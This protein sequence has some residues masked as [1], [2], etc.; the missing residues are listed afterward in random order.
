MYY[1]MIN[2]KLYK[3]REYLIVFNGE[4]RENAAK[5]KKNLEGLY[6]DFVAAWRRV[7]EDKGKP[8][9]VKYQTADDLCD[10]LGIDKNDKHLGKYLHKT[11]GDFINAGYI[12]AYGCGWYKEGK[13]STEL[14]H[15]NAMW[16]NQMAKAAE[17]AEKQGWYAEKD[18]LIG[19]LTRAHLL[20]NTIVRRGYDYQQL[21][22]DCK[23]V[24][25]TLHCIETSGDPEWKSV[26]NLYKL[27]YSDSARTRRSTQ[28]A[29][30][31]SELRSE[32]VT[33]GKHAGSDNATYD[34]YHNKRENNV[35]RG[36]IPVSEEYVRFYKEAYKDAYKKKF[37]KLNET[38]DRSVNE[39]MSKSF[40]VYCKTTVDEESYFF[41]FHMKNW[42]SEAFFKIPLASAGFVKAADAFTKPHSGHQLQ[43]IRDMLK[44]ELEKIQ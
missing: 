37:A 13:S 12:L 31:D 10:F 5:R 40:V 14:E 43:V 17:E 15:I 11:I 24:E 2:S 1:T 4:R 6:N 36:N 35:V 34:W 32:A 39:M 19:G 27:L 30:Y 9:K 3:V 7:C 26:I 28:N 44:Q 23:S 16:S 18:E 22:Q 41:T 33:R 38:G 21:T 29:K 8:R 42:P 20:D 25:N